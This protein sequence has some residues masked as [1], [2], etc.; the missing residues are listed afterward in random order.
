MIEILLFVFS[1]YASQTQ[2]RRT[3]VIGIGQQEDKAWGKIN[4]DRDVP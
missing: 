4:G 3:L 2:M 1:V